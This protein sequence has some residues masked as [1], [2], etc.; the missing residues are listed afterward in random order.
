MPSFKYA[1]HRGFIPDP[2]RPYRPKD[3]AQIERVIQYARE[4]FYKGAQFTGIEDMRARARIWCKEVAGQRT[5]GTIHRKP[6]EVFEQ[7]ELSC[8]NNY[9]GIPF[10]MRHWHT[11]KVQRDHHVTC[12]YA[13]YSI[14]HQRDLL[15]RQ[16]EI[17]RQRSLVRIYHRGQLIK[18][19][20]RQEKGGRIT[21]P[22]DLPPELVDYAS[23]DPEV[24]RVRARQL[25]PAAARYANALLGDQPTWAK[26][27]SGH[28]LIKLGR[29]FGSDALENACS[30]AIAVDL[31][32]IRRLKTILLK[33]LDRDP[34]AEPPA[35][36]PP[37]RFARPGAVFA[38]G[39]N[40]RSGKNR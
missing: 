12:Q 21:D 14:P 10:E 5:H 22:D 34:R 38:H 20:P 32:D 29:R 4:R 37:G 25:G 16:V 36:P 35:L 17:R 30:E 11:A 23:R 3:K 15:G 7:E 24:V 19:H 26:L 31:V 8:L 27:R 33:S 40:G 1:Q 6:L 39:G 28:A 9:D 2:T 18:V 13:L